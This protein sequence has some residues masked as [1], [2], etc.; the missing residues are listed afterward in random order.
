MAWAGACDE[1]PL[2]RADY[3]LFTRSLVPMHKNNGAVTAQEPLEGSELDKGQR[4]E[5]L[6]A[7]GLPQ[8]A[9]RTLRIDMC[10]QDIKATRG[11]PCSRQAGFGSRGTRRERRQWGGKRIGRFRDVIKAI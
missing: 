11:K 9:G 8:G 3:E 7:L 2:E 1:S 10:Y 5:P 6:L 4:E